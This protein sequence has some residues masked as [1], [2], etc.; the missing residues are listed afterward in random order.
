MAE[1]A[2]RATDKGNRVLFFV[3]RKE[4]VDQVVSTFKAQGVN[5]SLAKIGMVQTI[6]RHVDKLKPPAIIFVDEAHHVLAKSY[7]RILDKFPQALKLLFTAT[8]YRLNGEGFEDVADDLILG[9]SVK[10]LIEDGFLAPVD[11]YAPVQLDVSQLKTKRNGEFDEKSIAEAFKPKVYG[12]AVKTFKKLGGNKQAIAYTYNVASAERLASEL[13]GNG[14]TARAVSGK[15][16]KDERDSIINDYRNGKIQVVTNAEL[17]TE[18]LDLP[19]VDV[20]IMLRPTQSLSLYLQFAM[21]C[22]NPRK[23][24]TAIIIDHVGN[25]NRFGLPTEPHHWKLEGNKKEKSNH[26]RDEIKPVT[27]CP[28]CFATF[29]RKG[30]N[31]PFCGA[32]LVE[33]KELAVVEDAKLEKVKEERLRKAHMIM[34]GGLAAKVADKKISELQNYEEVKAYAKFKQYKPGWVY[35]YSKKRGFI[36]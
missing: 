20:V 2:R 10:K 29:Y 35:F 9:N 28:E 18:G 23:G 7:R 22:M 4:I 3:H 32:D 12:N 24:K 6:T 13:N 34:N 11:Y 19:N 17:F 14:I 1:I 15:T 16:P 26:S 36:K 5:M 27:T 8:P 21:R 31:C 33:E 25:V 30:D